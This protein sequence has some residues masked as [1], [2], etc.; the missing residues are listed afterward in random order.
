MV[1]AVVPLVLSFWYGAWADML[2]RKFLMYAFLCAQVIHSAVSL[3]MAIFIYLP[4]EYY[5]VA[6]LPVDLVGA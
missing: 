2:G 4:K 6:S 1:S 3:I 5:Y